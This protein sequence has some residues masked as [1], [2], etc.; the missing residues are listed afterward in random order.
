MF[1]LLNLRGVKNQ[2]SDNVEKV[3]DQIVNLL[4]QSVEK[5]KDRIT[6]VCE[7]EVEQ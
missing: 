5:L 4:Q 3:V 1:G 6:E 2:M 7:S